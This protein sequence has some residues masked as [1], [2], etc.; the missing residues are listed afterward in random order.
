MNPIL[1]V[2]G[3]PRAKI[4]NPVRKTAR[5]PPRECHSEPPLAHRVTHRLQVE[6]LQFLGHLPAT[7]AVPAVEVG[8]PEEP[9]VGET[10]EG[11]R[12]E[13][14]RDTD[15]VLRLWS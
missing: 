8:G 6:A 3:R 9:S 5:V 10:A 13:G 7:Q 14:R 15:S 1:D 2:G 12:S 11:H 4:Q